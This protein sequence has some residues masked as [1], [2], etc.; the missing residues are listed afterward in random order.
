MN[1]FVI[2]LFL[3]LRSNSIRQL[4]SEN[5]ALDPNTMFNQARSLEVAQ[6]SLDSYNTIYETSVNSLTT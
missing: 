3:G 5:N 2:L 4:L 1:L 6:K